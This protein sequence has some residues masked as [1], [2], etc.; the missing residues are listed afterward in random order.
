M[1]IEILKLKERLEIAL[2]LGESHYREFKSGQEGPPENKTNRDVKSV[3]EDISRTLVAFAN[4]D[5]GELLV[6]V[7][8]SGQVS[9]LNYSQEKL[10][11]L[12]NAPKTHVHKNTPLPNF[13]SR[14]TEYNGKT[15]LYFSIPKGNEFVYLTSDGRCIQRKDLESVPISAEEILFSR[16]ETISREYDR[17]FIENADISDIDIELISHITEQLSIKITPEKFL[18]HIDL[19]EF[20]GNKLRLKRAALLLFAKKPNRWHPRL[21]VRVI[22]VAG[23]ELKSGEDFNV[24]NDEEISDNVVKLIESSWEI[25]R[26]HLTETKFSKQAL[27]K[28]QIVYPELAC[29]EAL[30]NA[31][32]HRDYSIEGRGIEVYVYS[33]RLEIQSPGELLSSVKVDDLEKQK[34]VHQSRNSNIAKALREIGYMRELGEGIRRIFELMR[35]NDL[36]AP[37][38]ESKNKSFKV[39]LSQKHVYSKEEKLW[40]DNFSQLNLTREQKT[41][42]RLGTN[43]KL[44]STDDIWEACGIVDTDKYRQL[45]ESMKELGIFRR[46]FDRNKAYEIAKKS[47]TSKK[48][49]KQFEIVIPSSFKT[50]KDGKGKGIEIKQARQVESNDLLDDLSYTKIYVTNIPFDINEI[51]LTDFF[52][53]F[54]DVVSVKIPRRF[55]SKHIRGFAYVEYGNP[56]DA[57]NA[58]KNS[59]KYEL[60]G[61][62]IY[63]Q[64]SNYEK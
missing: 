36:E 50:S 37:Q 19:A 39:T 47:R 35:N 33:D 60:K 62:K 16:E 34:G 1:D 56:E 4:A 52:N 40:L 28:T 10:E 21:Q 23:V 38:F 9:G 20:D 53:K 14:I 49:I 51:D 55:Q 5:G 61:R 57:Q 45:L 54:G 29:R 2:E 24:I 42:V 30:I 15:I 3:C 27:F 32:A 59:S 11:I 64:K 7:E 44:F 63:I 6:G 43:G 31:I 22:K 25:I 12:L 8:D 48:E 17:N 13:R 26:P 58:I 41:V 18:Q 46:N